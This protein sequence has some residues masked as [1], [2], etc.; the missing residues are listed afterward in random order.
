MISCDKGE[1]TL[2]GNALEIL[3]DISIIIKCVVYN[4]SEKIPKEVATD[5]VRFSVNAG[6]DIT[7][8]SEDEILEEKRMENVASIL[9]NMMEEK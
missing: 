8:K 7:G 4:F 2:D 5:I 9:K 6:F 1:I 3:A